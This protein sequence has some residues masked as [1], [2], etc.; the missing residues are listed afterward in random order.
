MELPAQ[1]SVDKERSRYALRISVP[2]YADLIDHA[3]L[4]ES[5]TDDTST[6]HRTPG[7]SRDFLGQT[8]IRIGG[9]AH[10]SLSS[11]SAWHVRAQY[12]PRPDSLQVSVPA[13]RASG[14]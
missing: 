10:G 7:Q 14:Y 4:I 12:C 2:F 8:A 3:D 5:G 9:G 6:T 1:N 13:Y 11:C